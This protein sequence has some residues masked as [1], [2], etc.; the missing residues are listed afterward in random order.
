MSTPVCTPT[1]LETFLGMPTGTIDTARATLLIAKAQAKCERIVSPVP[2]DAA[3]IVLEVAARA[4]NNVAGSTQ[5]SLGSASTSLPG[6]LYLSKSNK[7]ELRLIAGRG[8]AFSADTLPTGTNAVQTVTVAAT[9]GTFT[10]TFQGATTAALAFD[11]TAAAVQAA[12][13]AL[14]SVGAGNVAVSGA[15]AVAFVNRLGRNPMPLLVA[16]GAGLAGGTVSVV[17]TTA[18]VT[19]PGGDLPP[20][21]RDYSSSLGY[22]YGW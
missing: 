19:A 3:D 16:D 14:P 1:E 15:Y 11:A 9:A 10:L 20:W 6:G 8:S 7:A 2:A 5:M 12:L 4:Y 21:G 18:G 17:T 13:E 22:T